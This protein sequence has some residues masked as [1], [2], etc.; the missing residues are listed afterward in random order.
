[1]CLILLHSWPEVG[2]FSAKA[3][4]KSSSAR[5]CARNGSQVGQWYAQHTFTETFPVLAQISRTS[6]FTA[7]LC[8]LKH[9]IMSAAMGARENVRAL[10]RAVSRSVPCSF[11][12]PGGA[13]VEQYLSSRKHFSG[14]PVS[15]MLKFD[16]SVWRSGEDTATTCDEAPSHHIFSGTRPV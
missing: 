2:G 12:A 14:I 6:S 7:A 1:M 3:P 15:R 13:T 10:G 5:L 8:L 11:P 4:W 16:T 9:T